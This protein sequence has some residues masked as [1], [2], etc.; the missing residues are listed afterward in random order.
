MDPQVYFLEVTNAYNAK[1]FNP[2][3]EE[4]DQ[5]KKFLRDL[6]KK[7][8]EGK[9][10]G[11]TDDEYDQLHSIYTEFSGDMITG[12]DDERNTRVEHDYPNLKGT[13]TKVHYVTEEEKENDPDIVKEYKTLEEWIRKTFR[14]GTLGFYKKIDG[15]SVVLSLD[16]YRRV[17]KAVTRGYADSD[18]G[19]DKSSLFNHVTI[20]GVIPE[21]FDR[22]RVGLK[23]EAVVDRTAYEEM[24]EKFFNGELVDP[25]AAAVSLLSSQNWTDQHSAYLT[26]APLMFECEGEI[27]PILDG[28]YGPSVIIETSNISENETIKKLPEAIKIVKEEIDSGDM[29]CDGIVVRW[30]DQDSIKALGR[31]FGRNTNNFETALKFRPTPYYSKIKDILQ[32]IGYMGNVSYTA[33]FEPI[34]IDGRTITHASLGSLNRMKMF[35]FAKGDLCR[36]TLN[37]V[38][39]IGIDQHT[40]QV[41]K[42]NKAEPIQSITHCPYCG[43]ELKIEEGICF[44]SNPDCSCRIMGKIYNFIEVMKIKGIGPET[45]EDLYHAGIVKEIQDLFKLKKH[46]DEILMLERFG[47]IAATNLIDAMEGV[48]GTEAQVL[49]SIGI[50]GVKTKK[51]QVLVDALGMDRILQL[52]F[53]PHIIAEVSKVK[54]FGL[55]TAEKFVQG[56]VANKKLLKFL[57]RHIQISKSKP[58]EL[59]AVFTG[60]RNPEFENH[61]LKRGVAVG[62]SITKDTGL[63][64]ALNPSASSGK[65]KKAREA[66]IPIVS[67]AEAMESFNFKR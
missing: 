42:E 61:L 25:R 7:Y 15:T 10:T 1:K 32:D 9:P 27:Y 45:V 40:I 14:K 62:D 19:I 39:R 31:N 57:L 35:N 22:K 48:K 51:A 44:C 50:P 28:Y 21:E 38:P 30:I 46:F 11:L 2:S 49:G 6:D 67:V 13:L 26:L 53:Q 66:G 5:M 20:N 16:E 18:L 37:T 12:E 54:G 63:V 36:V 65:L 52:E 60:V 64:I 56:I 3:K 17:R 43:K 59:K 4:L 33:E 58:I 23:I 24:N 34:E 47:P 29:P 55:V 8:R 41:N